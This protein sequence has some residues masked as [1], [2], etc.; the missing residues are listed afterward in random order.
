[1]GKDSQNRIKWKDMIKGIKG[2]TQNR[3][4]K[5]GVNGVWVHLP[6]THNYVI[7]VN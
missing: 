2:Y 3:V 6:T 5:E 7:S 4:A 1:M